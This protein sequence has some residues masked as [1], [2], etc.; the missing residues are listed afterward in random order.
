MYQRIIPNLFLIGS[1]KSGTSSLH[2]YLGS[3]PEI[4]MCRPKEPCFFVPREQLNWP[5]IEAHGFWRG[6]DYYLR[7][8]EN[9]G[10]AMFV[11]ESSTLYTKAPQISG[12]AERIYRF[13][14]DARFIYI[15]RD[16]VKRTFSH[17]WHEVHK[18]RERRGIE[19]AL[20]SDSKYLDVS[21]YAMQLRE[22]FQYFDP[23]QFLAITLEELQAGQLRG[24][25]R[26]FR[27]LGVEGNF[28]PENIHTRHNV[29][30]EV[31]SQIKGNGWLHSM[32]YSRLWN[33]VGPLVP[34]KVRSVALKLAE[35]R[36]APKSV[37]TSGLIPYLRSIQLPQTEELELLLGRSFPEWKTLH[38]DGEGCGR[39]F[40][41]QPV[42]GE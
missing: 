40:T 25:Q 10:N 29:T 31:V 28:E 4:F 8:F 6:E 42:A 15:L 12:V 13:N 5:E 7:L 34:E 3:H 26:I 9:A 27:W 39:D 37:D 30:N 36:V 21:Y 11:G 17:Y 20:R 24:V 35:E 18:K 14:P 16:P 32:R 2:S 41:P 19:A 22:Y 1:M 33:S 38:G 23:R